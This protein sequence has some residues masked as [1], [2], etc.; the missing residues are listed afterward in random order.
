M[1]PSLTLVQEKN[2]KENKTEFKL[3][4]NKLVIDGFAISD[5]EMMSAKASPTDKIRVRIEH[6]I[7]TFEY[8]AQFC[9]E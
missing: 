6:T 3:L 4:I 2:H 7:Q 5:F 1:I 8:F 9:S